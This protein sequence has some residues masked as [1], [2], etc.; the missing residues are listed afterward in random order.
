LGMCDVKEATGD[1]VAA[2]LDSVKDDNEYN[3]AVITGEVPR[4]CIFLAPWPWSLLL[5]VVLKKWATNA[6]IIC[7]RLT[8]GYFNSLSEKNTEKI[9]VIDSASFCLSLRQ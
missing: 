8:F 1:V 6:F 5:L 9:D 3:Q 7:M 4:P 2:N